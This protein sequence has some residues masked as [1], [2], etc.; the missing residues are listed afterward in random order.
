[1]IKKA[2]AVSVVAGCGT[3]VFVAYVVDRAIT[4]A[5]HGAW[6]RQP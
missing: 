5:I 1:M 2:L 4:E 3:I 6:P